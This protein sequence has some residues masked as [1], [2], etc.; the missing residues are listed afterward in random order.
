MFLISLFRKKF[1]LETSIKKRIQI[2]IGFSV[3]VGLF[4]LIFQPFGMA[5]GHR[6][7]V[8]EMALGAFLICFSVMFT[9]SVGLFYFFPAIFQKEKWTIGKE[10]A[11]ALL[12]V[13]VIA[14]CN[15]LFASWAGFI[16]FS[17]LGLLEFEFYT[18]AVAIIPMTI[19]ISVKKYLE[20]ERINQQNILYKEKEYKEEINKETINSFLQAELN[21]NPLPITF[22][23][24][25]L[26]PKLEKQ[27]NEV[28]QI[29][30]EVVEVLEID[31]NSSQQ[32]EK[33][34]VVCIP[35]ENKQEN[36]KLEANNLIYIQAADNYLEIIFLENKVLS[37][38]LIRNTLKSISE[39]I[40]KDF[41]QFF[42]CHKSYLINLH[43]VKHL[44]GN[45]QGYKLYL[46]YGNEPI[47]VSRQNNSII[48][49]KIEIFT[50]KHV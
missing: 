38:K 16:A 21:T 13:S 14:F 20:A 7:T 44:S 50:K 4:L 42:R 12:N 37:K 31:T 32:I 3:A 5:Y 30:Q 23:P 6:L 11:L 2:C 33:N 18:V 17:F 28:P 25:F 43:Q 24:S 40:E 45:A 49:Q 9:F 46:F 34:R 15:I 10:I 22:S 39:L 41:P 27:S 35:T 47:P 48:K 1:Y 8:F 26:L 19:L 36:F 29:A